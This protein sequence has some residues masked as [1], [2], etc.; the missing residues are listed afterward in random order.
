MKL[1]NVQTAIKGRKGQYIKVQWKSYP[2]LKAAYSGHTVI[3]LTTATIKTGINPS[4]NKQVIKNRTDFYGTYT[5]A[6]ERTWGQYM[7]GYK[8]CLVEHTTKTGELNHYLHCIVDE[9]IKNPRT[10]IY[11]VD[12]FPINE[13]QL[14]SL[15]YV[16][17]SYWNK[18]D[19]PNNCFDINVENIERI[20]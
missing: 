12:N 2:K 3:K 1:Q 16:Q 11:I 19:N 8:W 15:G 13:D 18:K 14:R 4:N 6:M 7:Q 9:A 5:P 20:F 17:D 10:V